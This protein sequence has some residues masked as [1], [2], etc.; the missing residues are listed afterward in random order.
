MYQEIISLEKLLDAWREFRRGKRS[1]ADV[2]AFERHLEDNIFR[3]HWEL[4]TKTYRHGSYHPFRIF[5]PKQ[6]LIHKADVRDRIVH[7]AVYRAL[8]PVFERSFIFDSYSC[9]TG[10]G[11]HAA[12]DRLERFV[13]KASRNNTK[14]CWALKCDIRKFFASIDHAILMELVGRKVCDPDTRQLLQ[15]I[16]GSFRPVDNFTERE[17]EREFMEFLSG[18]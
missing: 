13:R 4:K 7:H 6:R 11:T 12:V 15:N 5:D 9:R 18:I 1:A 2:Q 3:L 8:A 14:P 17:R 16:I 10:K